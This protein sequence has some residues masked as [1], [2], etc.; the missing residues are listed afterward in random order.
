MPNSVFLD[1]SGWIALHNSTERMHDQANSLWHNLGRQ[2]FRVVV[3]DWIIAETGNGLSRSRARMNFADTM[4]QLWDSPVVDVVFVNRQLISRAVD[5]YRRHA[6]KS[7]GLVDCAS[8]VVMQ[9]RR[10]TDA[11]TTDRHFEQAGFSFL[12]AAQ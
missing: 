6:D 4:S 12:L 10:I 3:T 2:A 8:F 5:L 11:F 9:D 7:W 1:T